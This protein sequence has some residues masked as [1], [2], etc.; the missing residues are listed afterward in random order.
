MGNQN[1]QLLKQAARDL[2]KRHTVPLPSRL[3]GFNR[4]LHPLPEEPS[5]GV[6]YTTI[7]TLLRRLQTNVL[8]QVKPTL[9][10]WDECHWGEHGRAGKILNASERAGIPVLGLTATPRVDRR[11]KVAF[12]RTYHQL[13]TEGYLARETIHNVRTQVRSG[14]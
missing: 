13:V 3:G 11:Y 12:R 9:L 4:A 6:I 1:W 5:H 10:V 7:H 8:R 2:R 14:S